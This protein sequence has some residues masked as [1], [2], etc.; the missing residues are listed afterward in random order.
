MEEMGREDWDDPDDCGEED[1]EPS[2]PVAET[3]GACL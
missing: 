2:E 1:E 3:M